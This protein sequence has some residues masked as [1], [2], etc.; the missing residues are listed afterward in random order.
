MRDARYLRAQADLCLEMARQVG[1]RATADNLRVEAARYHAEAT[2][3]ET[4]IKTW[5]AKAA[6]DESGF[7]ELKRAMSASL[8]GHL[9][10]SAFRLSTI[11][12]SMSL[13]GSC[14]SSES[15]PGRPSI[16]GFEDEA[17]QS[18]GR[19]CHQ[20]DGRSALTIAG[21]ATQFDAGDDVYKL[22]S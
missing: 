19:P 7:L 18:L 6:P 1:D 12:A 17:E 21:F 22:S 4:G 5:V 9:G 13:A 2:E 14:F 10:S 15:A 3:I 8:I 20:T 16:M 11:T